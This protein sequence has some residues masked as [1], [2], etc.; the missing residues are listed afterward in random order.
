MDATTSVRTRQRGDLM[1]TTALPRRSA[2][3]LA[4]PHGLR[5]LWDRQLRHYP[6]NGPRAFYLGLTVMVTVTLYYEF[7]VQGSVATRII[8][9]HSFT[10][11]SYVY[12][13][14]I[15]AAVEAGASILAGLADRWGRANLVVYG[16]PIT[17]V[18]TLWGLPHAGSR[19]TFTVLFALLSAVEGVMLVAT[20]ALIRDFSP[21]VGRGLAMGFWALGPVLGSLVVTEV[22]SGTLPT[23][24]DWRYQF[25][26]CGVVGLVVFVVALAGLREL[27][28]GL[29][30]QL[31]VSLQDR[32]LIEARAAGLDVER[33]L[34]G[35]WRKMLRIDVVGSSLGI[36]IYLLVYYSLVVFNVVYLAT[37][38]GYSEARANAL[39]NWA[40]IANAIALVVVGALSDR[41][42]V[43][44][45]FMILGTAISLVGG[46]L[47]AAAATH[48]QSYHT[49]AVYLVLVSGGLATTYVAWMAGFTE[50][51][52]RH[53]PA[54]T[55]TGLAIFGWTIR[56]V[57]TVAFIVFTLV[58]PATSTLVDTAPP[59]LAMQTAHPQA[60]K[61]LTGLDPTTAQ[62]LA[63]AGEAP[64]P[65]V[66]AKAVS[67]VALID[68]AS[69]ST[70]AAAG[71]AITAGE[72][73]AAQAIDATTLAALKANPVDRAAATRAVVEIASKLGVAPAQ[74][75][76]LLQ[77]LATPDVQA[78]LA[79]AQKY[80]GELTAASTAFTVDQ[81]AYL[82]VH[83]PAVAAAAKDGPRQWQSW[84]WVCVAAQVLFVPFVFLMAGRWSPA[85]ARRDSLAH[86]AAV[87]RELAA[88]GNPDSQHAE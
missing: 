27:S 61:I 51:V 18:I 55:A 6:D 12:V 15:G 22:A 26:L 86:E 68:G 54:A 32:A 19:T 31:M 16:L 38:Y 23:H 5:Q 2:D 24:E 87:T 4:S 42:L 73:A 46:M 78:R 80:G 59:I 49:L 71:E 9:D 13:Q 58:V 62:A 17:G 64:L 34:E 47:F 29:R 81:L 56:S 83:G 66:I 63:A 60:F 43:R 36:A 25:Q 65:T 10:F 70:A 7:Y 1:T 52:E 50:T 48:H 53:N 79:L 3:S 41:L 45:P 30:D 76:K 11:T 75:V 21:Q 28:P 72:A 40:W 8:R 39:G 85:S 33:A 20:P 88:M 67:E 84:W 69:P 14:V 44:K 74:A 57:V 35:H 37:V 82:R 77:T